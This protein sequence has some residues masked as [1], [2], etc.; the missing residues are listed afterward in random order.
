VNET[1]IDKTVMTKGFPE[2]RE[3]LVGSLC[4]RDLGGVLPCIS[5][6]GMCSAKGY[7]FE[8]FWSEIG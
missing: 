1:P 4:G 2:V 7:G 8:P 5:Y 3:K 6:I